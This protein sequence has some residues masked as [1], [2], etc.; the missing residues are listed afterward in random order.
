MSVIAG[1]RLRTAKTKGMMLYRVAIT[2]WNKEKMHDKS[3]VPKV[4]FEGKG[5]NIRFARLKMEAAPPQ[6]DSVVT[7]SSITSGP[8]S[9]FLDPVP[10]PTLKPRVK[11]L[12][13]ASVFFKCV[14]FKTP[15]IS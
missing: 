8:S 14:F 4:R 3:A 12:F 1:G 10:F 2:R 11:Y 13:K 15:L 5:V 6:F 7:T 9:L